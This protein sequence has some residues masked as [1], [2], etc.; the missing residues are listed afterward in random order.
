MRCV[1]TSVYLCKIEIIVFYGVFQNALS[2]FTKFLFLAA[3]FVATF[4]STL[5]PLQV[6]SRLRNVIDQE[7]QLL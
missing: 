5:L 1:Y 3:V 4:V 2:D 6:V 7:R